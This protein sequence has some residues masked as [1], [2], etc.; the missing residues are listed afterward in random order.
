MTKASLT[1]IVRAPSSRDGTS[2]ESPSRSPT[3]SSPSRSPGSPGRGISAW[4]A[5]ELKYQLRKIF[6]EIPYSLSALDLNRWMHKN[7]A[8]TTK[9][10]SMFIMGAWL[11]PYIPDHS[12]VSVYS[13]KIHAG[14]YHRAASQMPRLLLVAAFGQQEVADNLKYFLSQ[15]IQAEEA[16]T[17]Q[18]VKI[19]NSV[20]P[21][22]HGPLLYWLLNE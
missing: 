19:V 5:D 12:S 6:W 17:V 16:L 22:D 4:N 9:I 7:A 8:D 3:R 15:L 13:N 20:V 11:G 18:D 1:D 2:V 21:K 10:N 14:V